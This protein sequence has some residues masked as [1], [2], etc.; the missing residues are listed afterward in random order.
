MEGEAQPPH[1]HRHK[2]REM[3]RLL[4]EGGVPRLRYW[5]LVVSYISCLMAKAGH[6]LVNA[7]TRV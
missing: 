1:F 3:K 2:Q 6:A 4:G 7:R 5:R